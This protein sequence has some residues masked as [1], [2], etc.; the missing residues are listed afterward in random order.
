MIFVRGGCCVDG[1]GDGVVILIASLDFVNV[2][3]DVLSALC[4]PCRLSGLRLLVLQVAIVHLDYCDASPFSHRRL[5]P[6]YLV[7]PAQTTHPS[8]Y[9]LVRHP[10][11]SSYQRHHRD[12]SHHLPC[13][14]LNHSP[15]PSIAPS[16]LPSPSLA[17]R[18]Y[19][20]PHS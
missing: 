1:R 15:V 3:G 12:H 5:S 18:H 13:L 16:S 10:F 2:F 11:S 19:G 6:V 20:Y 17:A 9:L 14:S 8:I 4:G 7:F